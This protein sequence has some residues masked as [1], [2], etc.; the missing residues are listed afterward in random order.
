MVRA[1]SRSGVRC[2]S[3]PDGTRLACPSSPEGRVPGSPWGPLLSGAQG[4]ARDPDTRAGRDPDRGQS[5]ATGGQEMGVTVVVPGGS[6]RCREFA[7]RTGEGPSW[8]GTAGTKAWAC[9]GR[10]RGVG[11]GPCRMRGE[12]RGWPRIWS[13]SRMFSSC[14][15]RGFEE[16]ESSCPRLV[17][18]HM[19]RCSKGT[20]RK[21]LH[22]LGRSK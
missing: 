9:D 18:S 17:P 20:G 16:K 2:A 19:E 15:R 5:T 11:T 7:G 22:F 12:R 21:G 14:S 1:A 6:P 8:Q 10:C 13:D 3:C 4:P